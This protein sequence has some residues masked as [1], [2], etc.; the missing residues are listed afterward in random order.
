[1]I[2]KMN[3]RDLAKAMQRMGIQQQEVEALEVII[4]CKDKDIVIE[5]PQVSKINAM[6]EV[7]WQVVGQ[8]VERAH[9]SVPD[10]KED[11]VLTVMEQASVSRDVALKA[12][13]DS[14]GDLADAILK[15]KQ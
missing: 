4:H 14:N 13:S 8:A 3:P 11:D 2:P 10:I 9:S 12:I 7:S 6:G 5:N 1:M 15:L